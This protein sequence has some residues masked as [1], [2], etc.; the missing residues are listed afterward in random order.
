MSLLLTGGSISSIRILEAIKLTPV[1]ISEADEETYKRLVDVQ[2][3]ILEHRYSKAPDLSDNPAY[4]PYATVRVG[5]KVVAEI[6]NNGFVTSSNAI[7][8]RIKD[9][10]SA[11]DG[12]GEGPNLAQARA[13][14]IAKLMGGT[15]EKASTAL[16]QAQFKTI[17]KPSVAVDYEALRQ[18]PLYEQLH[19]TKQARTLFLAQQIAQT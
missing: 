16:T 5:G 6:D 12:A 11:A 18:D 7:G 15:V 14:L 8:A 3:T 1:K 13:E 10:L 9:A 4:K 19:R 2:Q 17:P